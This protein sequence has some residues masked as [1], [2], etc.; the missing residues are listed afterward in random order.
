MALLAVGCGAT[1][2]TGSSGYLPVSGSGPFRPVDADFAPGLSAPF[3]LIDHQADLDDPWV[4][5]WGDLLA[6]WVT[7]RRANLTTI[8]HADAYSLEQGFGPLVQAFVPTEAWEAGA[9]SSPSLVA[10]DPVV[11]GGIWLLF[12]SGGGAIGW[13]TA[14]AVS[15]G[16]SWTKAPG[17]ALV[18]D[19]AEEGHELASPAVVRLGDRVR[20][21]YL[22]RGAIWA[23]EASWTDVVDRQPTVW[24][25]LDGDPTTPER[26]PMLRPPPWAASLGRFTARAEATPIGRL[27]HDLYFSATP[28]ATAAMTSPPTTCGFASS[29]TGDRFV[30]ASDPI[31]PSGDARRSPAETPY[32]D[33]ALLLYVQKWGTVGAVA[34]ALSP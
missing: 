13:A 19:G 18:A 6:L 30:S 23:A 11:P 14:T 8:E 25:R 24:T 28:I 22:A 20:V 21:Y 27:R 16:H 15:L 4:V 26:D 10:G 2:E 1:A 12:Y 7:S 31:L 5:P 33:E 29:F 3:L 9:I 32:R 17:P 34:A